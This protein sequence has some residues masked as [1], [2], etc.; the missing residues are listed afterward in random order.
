MSCSPAECASA[1]TKRLNQLHE[2]CLSGG[3]Q[4]SITKPSVLGTW[5]A[6]R[7]G[8]P[9]ST[10][11]SGL[12]G[13]SCG[14]VMV[15]RTKAALWPH[16][17][18][19]CLSFSP[20]YYQLLYTS[21]PS[22]SFFP[23]TRAIVLLSTACVMPERGDHVFSVFCHTIQL[24]SKVASPKSLRKIHPN[25]ET[26]MNQNSQ[27]L[28]TLQRKEELHRHEHLPP[29]AARLQP[30]FHLFTHGRN[31]PCFIYRT[32]S[33]ENAKPRKHVCCD[34]VSQQTL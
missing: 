22:S 12:Q 18:S 24:S 9:S 15:M 6:Q 28:Q 16:E 31:R 21:D 32:R 29:P 23:W 11:A 8:M 25:P 4:R 14:S 7:V 19:W 34:T 26:A 13:G 30:F 17:H 20:C 2:I 5:S 10:T 33:P 3:R 1:H 27:G